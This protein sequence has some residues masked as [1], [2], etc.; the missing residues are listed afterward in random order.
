MRDRIQRGWSSPGWINY[1]LLPVTWIYLALTGIRKLMYRYGIFATGHLDAP[2][3]VVG[4]ISSGGSGKTPLVIA[5]ARYLHKQGY[6]PGIISRGYGG[7]SAYWPRQVDQA[8]TAE[9]VGD[10][11]QLM[12]ELAG[13]PVVVGPDRIADGRQLLKDNGC[14]V[15]VSD[16]GF[17]H[18]RLHRDL[19]IVVIDTQAGFGNGWCLPSGPLREP[20]SAL[21]RAGMIVINGNAETEAALP[22]ALSGAMSMTM[23][24]GDCYNLVTGES[25]D[26]ASFSGSMVNAVAGIGN[27][28]RFFRQLEQTGIELRRHPFPDHYRFLPSDL[29]F[30]NDGPVLMTEKDGIK[31]RTMEIKTSVWIVRANV[32][33]D[34]NFYT[35]I[36]EFM[37]QPRDP[38]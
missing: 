7:N 15:V 34:P 21:Q 30:E 1:L 32:D 13:V 16:D 19:D 9:L 11:P 28:E 3:I 35:R 10:E 17:Q 31:C 37:N 38:A 26:L 14:D 29:E 5:L 23:N 18:F 6:R 22:G 25:R 36:D 8:T 24:P 27:P 33:L 20:V 2:V 4:G 12:Y